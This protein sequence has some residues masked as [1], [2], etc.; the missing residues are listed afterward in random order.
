MPNGLVLGLNAYHGDV[1]AA[2]VRDGRLIA[3][4]EEERFRRIKHYAGFPHLALAECLRLAGA[5]PADVD[6]FA[7]SRNPRAHLWRKAL[8]LLRYRPS[9]TV[10]ERARNMSKVGSLPA[11]IAASVGLDERVVRPRTRFIEHH[12]SHLASAA[13]VSPF[14][15]AAVCAIDGFGD[16]VSTSWGRVEGSRLQ[17]DRRVFFP[18]S[19]GLLYLAIT[20]FLGFAKYGDEFKVMGLAPYGEPRFVR[21][22]ST[23]VHLNGD[24]GFA[25]DLSYFR[26][27]SDGV[28]MTWE[29]G[30]PVIGRVFTKKLY[31]LLGP[32]RLADEPLDARHEAIAASLQVVYERAAMHVLS[33]VQR[34]T[35]ATRLCLA[36]GCGMNSVANGKIREQ[37]DFREV[38]IQPAAGD[39]GT[40]LGAAYHAWHDGG[41]HP[42]DFVMEHGYWGPEFGDAEIAAV[43]DSDRTAIDQSDCTR[44]SWSD[45]DA[46]DAWTAEQIAAGRVVG[47]FQG[48]M[49]WGAR[50][51]GNRS[52]VA[53][54]RRADMRDIINTRI[55]FRER[56]RPFAPS[57]LE[58]AL[59]E[60]FVGAVPDPF[61]LQVYPVR[62]DKR[63]TVPAITHVDGSG[64]LQ[65]VSRRSNPRYWKLIKAF[66]RV[67]GVPML[68]NT[69]FNENEP[70]VL[71][72][73]E[74]LDCFLRTHMDIIVMGPHVLERAAV[75]T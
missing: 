37:T 10:G 31:S 14:D 32:A 9:G 23:L 28:A 49:E 25:L 73:Q 12:P 27:W 74:A 18:H 71:R 65:T 8:F 46:L 17:V 60:Y 55:K 36:G 13:F 2:L 41:S 70:I 3:A 52:I 35:G 34:S 39:N 57:V 62:P 4:V 53:D 44:R 6:V 33:H 21:E 75:T 45:P 47:W 66:E 11:T 72:P 54:P 48:R 51:L 69:S 15:S 7:V 56:F 67:S 63:A 61:M 16:F 30:E 19:L 40:A 29:E 24:G 68:L 5:R 43:L 64:R 26:H 58:E 20:Q 1:S 42:R 50:A 38:F 22:L 59:D